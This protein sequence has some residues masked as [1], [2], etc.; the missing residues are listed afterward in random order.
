MNRVA[1]GLALGGLALLV[2]LMAT[3]SKDTVADGTGDVSA[4]AIP[5]GQEAPFDWSSDTEVAEAPSEDVVEGL[6]AIEPRTRAYAEGIFISTD[7]VEAF[8]NQHSFFYNER[9][10]P[11]PAIERIDF[12][13]AGEANSALDILLGLTIDT[14]VVV[15]MLSG[16]FVSHEVDG[17]TPVGKT[18]YLVFHAATGNL[19]LEGARP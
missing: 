17:V 7:D 5:E 18:G 12:M 9:G 14:P 15:A 3:L 2:A 1:F 16:D 8:V 19:L 6:K 10:S 13:T 11:P 4:T